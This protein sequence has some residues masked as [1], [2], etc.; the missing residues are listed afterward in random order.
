MSQRFS[1]CWKNVGGSPLVN[2]WG[3][4]FDFYNEKDRAYHN[5]DHI[6]QGLKEIDLAKKFLEKPS[7]LELAWYFHDAIYDPKRKDNEEKSAEFLR[8][9][10]N[11]SSVSNDRL[12]TM[13]QLILDTKHLE[14]PKTYD[15]KF[16]CDIDLSIF[17]KSEIIYNK[18]AEN[19]RKEYLGVPLK[20]YKAHRAEV[21]KRFLERPAIYYTEFFSQRYGE[22]ARKNLEREIESLSQ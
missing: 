9:T 22:V 12:K 7:E 19:I 2:P 5:M 10:L 15:G 8:A 17:G 14:V 3:F 1:D 11:S 13:K 6:L 21:L 20:D 16:I 4:L 18:Y